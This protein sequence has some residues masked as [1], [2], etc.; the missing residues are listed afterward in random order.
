MNGRHDG[1]SYPCRQNI[2]GCPRTDDDWHTV[3]TL[4]QK[5]Q[6]AQERKRGTGSTASTSPTKPHQRRRRTPKLPS[7]PKED[8]KI[9]VRPHQGLPLKIM[10]TPALAEAIATAC[11]YEIRGSNI[12]ILSTPSQDVAHWALQISSLTINGRTHAVNVYAATGEDAIRGL[13]QG[14]SPRTPAET[15]KAN[16][17]IRTQGVELIH[18]KMIGD[19]DQT[20]ACAALVDSETQ[21]TDTHVNLSALH[22]GVPRSPGIGAA[23]DALSDRDHLKIDNAPTSLMV[24]QRERE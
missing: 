14:L 4:R 24:Q 16:L 1:I 17:R 13:I 20:W 19:T 10:S 5:K 18:A 12:T 21:R 2:E 3:L 6:Q 23:N 7:L 15:I 8:F 11:N 22:A 9:V